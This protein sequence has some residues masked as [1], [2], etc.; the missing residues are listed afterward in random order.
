MRSSPTAR[1]SCSTRTSTVPGSTPSRSNWPA[2]PRTPPT[3]R[4][5]ASN[6]TP[7]PVSRPGMLHEGA[8]YTFND[9]MV[10][11]PSR[12]EWEA[13]ILNAQRAPALA[14]HHRVAGR[15]GDA[16]HARGLPSAGR[17]TDA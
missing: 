10:P 3:R 11:L 15:L 2:S 9:T 16:G 1:S 12:E 13:A 8:A 7:R 17:T 6:E 5:A 14:G 4:T